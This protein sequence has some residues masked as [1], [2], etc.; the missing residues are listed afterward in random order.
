MGGPSGKIGLPSCSDQL[1]KRSTTRIILSGL[2]VKSWIAAPPSVAG[3]RPSRCPGCSAAG[4]PL[5]GRLV[6]VGHGLRERSTWGPKDIESP[7]EV[8]S[9]TQRRYRC[10]AC[11]AVVLVR[12]RGLGARLR[13]AATAVALA[14]FRWGHQRRPSHCVHA[15]ISPWRTDLGTRLHGWR[16]LSRWARG[17]HKI[18]PEVFPDQHATAMAQ[19]AAAASQVAARATCGA[20]PFLRQV[21]D[22]AHEC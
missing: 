15:E 8:G 7:A 18:W 16:Q 6:I 19:A 4:A 10:R 12:P 2:D 20:A 9:V 21:W 22:G 3:A 11:R 13:Y 5:G 17:A 1:E 14:L